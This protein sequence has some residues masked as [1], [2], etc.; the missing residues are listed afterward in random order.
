V[1]VTLSASDFSRDYRKFN[2]SFPTEP[3][4]SL[5]PGPRLILGPSGR[6]AHTMEA[7]QVFRHGEGLPDLRRRL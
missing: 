5:D 7:V 2:A 1:I 3:L 6:F 4:P